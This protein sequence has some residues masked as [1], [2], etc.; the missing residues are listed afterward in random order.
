[1]SVGSQGVGVRRRV[2]SGHHCIQALQGAQGGG[3]KQFTLEPFLM[4]PLLY[5]SNVR[6]RGA[7]AA[8]PDWS[9][10]LGGLL[11]TNGAGAAPLHCTLG[12]SLYKFAGKGRRKELFGA[13]LLDRAV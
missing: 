12:K 11:V 10:W 13:P 3:D 5:F 7:G 1:M 6:A 9:H 4:K 8:T 2:L